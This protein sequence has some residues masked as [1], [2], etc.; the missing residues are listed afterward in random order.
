MSRKDVEFQTSDGLTLRGWLYT[1]STT[2]EKL[3]CLIMSHG[4]AAIK[5][6]GLDKFAEVFVAKLPL[7]CL[8][9]DHRSYGSS[10][11]APGQ[12]QHEVVPS[13]QQS[14]LQDAITYAQGLPNI[15]ES[16]IALWGS[17]FSGG[18]VLQI[19]AIDRR[20][21]A[22]ISQVSNPGTSKR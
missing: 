10:D 2:N 4:W 20:V 22:V 3:P 7:A 14:D 5:E 13:L 15:N 9:Y 6:M 19:A 1:P 8:V 11:T 21:K 12:P 17:S 18:H 16:K